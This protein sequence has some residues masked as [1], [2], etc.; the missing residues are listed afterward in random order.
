M[1]PTWLPWKQSKHTVQTSFSVHGIVKDI[2]KEG[3]ILNE[4]LV[5]E[6]DKSYTWLELFCFF[7][8]FLWANSFSLQTPSSGSCDS[9]DD[10]KCFKS[11]TTQT[12]SGLKEELLKNFFTLEEVDL[13]EK[14]FPPLCVFC[15]FC[16]V[17]FCSALSAL[18]ISAAR[19][20][21]P[22]TMLKKN[23]LFRLQFV[24]VHIQTSLDILQ[25]RSSALMLVRRSDYCRS[26]P[27]VFPV[28]SCK[29]VKKKKMWDLYNRAVRS[30]R[31]S[32]TQPVQM[33]FF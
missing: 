27:P 9:V 21:F 13:W 15:S 32:C 3:I 20:L 16:T 19:R 5:S 7:Y 29:H 17:V 30:G 2:S 8:Y 33:F 6:K 31:D 1:A 18:R 22:P 14:L 23:T 28:L 12:C 4:T 25:G 10:D 26:L 24:C 11:M